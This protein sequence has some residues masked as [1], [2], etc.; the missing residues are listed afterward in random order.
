MNSKA[1]KYNWKK[2]WARNYTPFMMESFIHV[3]Q[4]TANLNMSNNKLVVP[5]GKLYAIYFEEK[6]FGQLTE[7]YKRLLLKKD[8][9][10]FAVA[11]E[12]SFK[13]FNN[14]SKKIT[15]RDFSKLTNQQ[16]ARFIK[17][18]HKKLI[19]FS[20]QQFCAFLVLEGMGRE[21]ERIF[22]EQP[23]ILHA[24]GTPYRF[25]KIVKARVELLKLKTR[26]KVTNKDLQ[27]YIRRNSWLSVY[28][29][30]DNLLTVDNVKEEL[31]GIKHSQTELK[32][33]IT[34]QKKDLKQYKVF[35]KNLK[36]KKLK[37]M[38][39]IVHA[40]AYLKEM[41]DDYR[42][43]AYYYYAGFWQEISKRLSILF[44][45]TNYLVS[46]ELQEVLMGSKKINYKKLVKE[47]KNSYALVLKEGKLSIYSGKKAN[48]ITALIKPIAHSKE[49]SGYTACQ[50]KAKG[51]VNIISHHGEL[52]KFKK[53][54]ILVTSMTHPE[55]ISIMKKASAI[56]TDEGGITCHAAIV[57]RELGIPC[58]IGT[59][60]ATKV[61]K[62]GDMVE[63][64]ATKGIV[65]KL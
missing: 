16:L 13:N 28:Q 54:D 9:K 57:S 7:N 53:G 62:D 43:H 37:K 24:I 33:L 45:E 6:E 31:S 38:V 65:K 58:I 44:T 23:E 61:F 15:D 1:N 10:D 27:N 14:W 30:T 4:K 36:D 34:N 19:I 60:I 21:I 2:L 51:R 63:V 22:A 8:I 39:A 47:R 49:L 32:R 46:E 50:G 40:F 42:R 17:V 41:R 48:T 52:K 20:E 26:G 59:K 3:F 56:V 35:V 12:Q 18:L 55:F 5:D 11:Y 29:F 64:D 25:T